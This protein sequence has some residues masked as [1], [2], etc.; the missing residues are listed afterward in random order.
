MQLLSRFRVFQPIELLV[1]L[2]NSQVLHYFAFFRNLCKK[3]T[4]DLKAV[5]S[6]KYHAFSKKL[7]I[8]SCSFSKPKSSKTLY[9]L[10][11]TDNCHWYNYASMTYSHALSAWTIVRPWWWRSWIKLHAF[12][13]N[14]ESEASWSNL[15]RHHLSEL[16]FSISAELWNLC[17][18]EPD[19]CQPLLR[20]TKTAQ[21]VFSADSKSSRRQWCLCS[22][23]TDYKEF[24]TSWWISNVSY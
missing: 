24:D 11:T 6:C 2:L 9:G 20:T 14:S 23:L 10:S 17:L 19:G 13:T 4:R 21:K 3:M 18:A 12:C 15:C 7:Q 5:E 22:N 16:G 1:H 8:F